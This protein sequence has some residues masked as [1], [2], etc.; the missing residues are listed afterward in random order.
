MLVKPIPGT[1]IDWGNPITKSLQICALY[2]QATGLPV[3]Q[4][5]WNQGTSRGTSWGWVGTDRGAGLHGV[6]PTGSAT[7]SAVGP[8]AS[9]IDPVP[10]FTGNFTVRIVFRLN[11][12]SYAGN[13]SIIWGSP[14]NG[15]FCI[16]T[17]SNYVNQ[18]QFPG[19]GTA[20]TT[21][22]SYGVAIGA[23]TDMVLTRTGNTGLFYNNGKPYTSSFSQAGTTSSKSSTYPGM[24]WG[25]T[26]Y[27]SADVT[28]I[29]YQFW[30]RALLA[31]EILNLWDLPNILYNVPSVA[32]IR[33]P[34]A[35]LAKKTPI[36]LF[37]SVLTGV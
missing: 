2:N 13:A 7:V 14:L 32:R 31:S 20:T 3:D 27:A 12:T 24:N 15:H 4:V 34:L 30:T 28:M 10:L 18:A 33:R 36:H 6:S 17:S 1:P 9:F 22:L 29:E 11:A 5:N 35:I 26:G 19:S 21:M 16:F 37:N 25:K 8:G 23:V